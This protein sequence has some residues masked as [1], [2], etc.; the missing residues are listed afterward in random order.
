MVGDGCTHQAD[1]RGFGK[2]CGNRFLP[3]GATM[4]PHRPVDEAGSTE[5]TAMPATAAN[6]DQQNIVEFSMGGQNGRSAGGSSGEI[7]AAA[8]DLRR[9]AAARQGFNGRQGAIR[10]I[11]DRI[12][13]RHV[14]ARDFPGKRLQ[15]FA[16]DG[17]AVPGLQPEAQKI[18]NEGFPFSHKDEI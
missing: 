11:R 16:A 9:G 13:R 8:N 1:S 4:G 10:T 5:P 2:A 6:F 7:R 15:Q 12:K 14:D 3:R 18:R 17:F